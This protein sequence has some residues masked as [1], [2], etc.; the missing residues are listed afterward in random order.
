MAETTIFYGFL[1]KKMAEN[2]SQSFAETAEPNRFPVPGFFRSELRVLRN[3]R[4]TMVFC[5]SYTGWGP[6]DS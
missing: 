5:G 2:G 6:Q 1:P 4:E 3:P